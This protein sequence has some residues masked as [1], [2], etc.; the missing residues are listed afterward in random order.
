MREYFSFTSDVVF[1]TTINNP[2]SSSDFI[3]HLQ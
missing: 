1:A 3:V 2:M